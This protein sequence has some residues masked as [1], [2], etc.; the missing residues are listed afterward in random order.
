MCYCA[1]T[2]ICLSSF[3]DSQYSGS[4]P[5]KIFENYKFELYVRRWGP[6][7][8]IVPNFIKI[9]QTVAE[10]WRFNGFYRAMLC[11]RGTSHGPVSVCPS[12]SVKSRSSTKTAKQRIT[13][14]TP[15]DSP[16]TLVFW[17]QRSPRNSTGVTPYEGAKCRWGGSK[18]TTFDKQ[19]AISRNLL[20]VPANFRFDTA[21]QRY[22]A[23]R[24]LCLWEPLGWLTIGAIISSINFCLPRYDTIRDAILTCARKLT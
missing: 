9:G 16:G 12:V 4:P 7:C 6:I 21:F 11:I 2:K 15:H 22:P 5:Y 18:S 10:I 1:M 24:E 13:Q 19:P 3:F 20:S 14:R 17:R 23:A 8:V